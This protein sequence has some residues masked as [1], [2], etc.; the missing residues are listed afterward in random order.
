MVKMVKFIVLA[1]A[2]IFVPCMAQ[3]TIEIVKTIGASVRFTTEEI[4]KI[5]FTAT[6]MIIGGVETTI[7]VSQIAVLLFHPDPVATE[8]NQESELFPIDA[9][10]NPNPFNPATTLRYMILSKSKVVIAVYDAEG[11]LLV[12]LSEGIKEAGQQS[13][14][15]DGRDSSGR[16]MGSGFYQIRL[17]VNYSTVVKQAILI[18]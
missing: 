5:T 7:P 17:T 18:R 13:C 8:K 3:D 11:K 16:F 10:V 1:L 15:W 9:S 12:K 4:T 14:T 6:D 2:L